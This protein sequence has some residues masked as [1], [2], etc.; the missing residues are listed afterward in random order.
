MKN[1]SKN[2]AEIIAK[3][4]VKHTE[5]VLFVMEINTLIYALSEA[6]DEDAL[7]LAKEINS[8]IN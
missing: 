6:L 1:K 8:N 4:L 7:E 3:N 2:F 5:D